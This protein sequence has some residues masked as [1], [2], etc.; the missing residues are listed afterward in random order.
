MFVGLPLEDAEYGKCGEL[1]KAMYGT[2]D[3]PQYWEHAYCE[4]LQSNGFVRWKSAPCVLLHLERQIRMVVHGDDFTALGTDHD[5]DWYRN[6]MKT[7]L[8]IKDAVALVRNF[9]IKSPSE[10]E[11]G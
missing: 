2:Q 7:R 1:N 8:E 10:F 5:L 4:F 11:I 6:L 9:G 3:A